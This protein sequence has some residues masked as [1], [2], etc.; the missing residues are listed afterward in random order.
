MERINV[1]QVEGALDTQSGQEVK[2]SKAF[3]A[4]QHFPGEN[5]CLSLYQGYIYWTR[6][7]GV[8]AETG[9]LRMQAREG[10]IFVETF[11]GRE[12]ITP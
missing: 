12:W 10:R 9:N 3:S 1:K 6:T 8:L 11:D 4:P 5:T 7:Q 2:G